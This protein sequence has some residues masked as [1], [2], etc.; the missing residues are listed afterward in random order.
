VNHPELGVVMVMGP[1]ATIENATIKS[2]G[3]GSTAP[4]PLFDGYGSN[5]MNGLKLK[6]VFLWSSNNSS[7]AP[8]FLADHVVIAFGWEWKDS[9][10]LCAANSPAS[11]YFVRSTIALL[12]FYGGRIN[13]NGGAAIKTRGGAMNK[14]L[15]VGFSGIK[16]GVDVVLRGGMA[17]ESGKGIFYDFLNGYLDMRDNSCVICDAQTA[18]NTPAMVQYGIDTWGNGGS[19][20]QG[21][22]IGTN[23]SL[24]GSANA[25]ATIKFV[26]PVGGGNVV[27]YGL[28]TGSAGAVGIDA[29]GGR[30]SIFSYSDTQGTNNISCDLSGTAIGNSAKIINYGP[31]SGNGP[32]PVC[33][34][35]GDFFANGFITQ[36]V[37]PGGVKFSN[38]G[39]SAA[40]YFVWNQGGGSTWSWFSADPGV[41]ANKFCDWGLNNGSAFTCYQNDGVT[42][43]IQW[44]AFNAANQINLLNPPSLANNIVNMGTHFRFGYNG[45]GNYFA[46][47]GT[48]TG[49]RLIT[50]PDISF[51]MAGSN[52]AQLWSGNQ[53]NVALV[54]PSIGGETVSASPRQPYNAFL[55]GALT[56]TWTG[57]TFTIDKAITVTRFQAQAKTAPAGCTTNAVVR[58]TDGTSPVNLALAAAANDSG[59]ITQNYAA[60]ATIAISVQ[61]AAAGCTTSPADV[62]VVVQYRMQ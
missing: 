35:S 21:I 37:F 28:I 2:V 54:T 40:R 42:P 34:G 3:S 10:T 48:P 5:S 30:P 50:P 26:G 22:F 36:N 44:S 31:I 52:I 17:S 6:G 20:N 55:P 25:A 15:G 61:T 38:P 1:Y 7:S 14:S 16:P 11:L 29:G 57:E 9:N 47:A 60:G 62:N 51:I 46:T 59:A 19:A 32:V 53:T 58:V 49:A 24:G 33:I 56:S 45:A 41:A 13:V 27:N 8:C 43:L 39:T 4:V 18:A 12:D 23:T